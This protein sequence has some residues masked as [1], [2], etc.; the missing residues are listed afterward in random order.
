MAKKSKVVDLKPK[1]DKV[2]EEHLNQLKQ[3]V[4]TLNSIQFEIGKIESQKHSYLHKLSSVQDGV[5]ALQDML[6]E[7]YGT[8]DV[9]LQ[10]GELNT[11]NNE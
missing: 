2:S 11:S 5:K 6:V 3:A 8:F 4:N 10:T 7:E 9:N 1:V